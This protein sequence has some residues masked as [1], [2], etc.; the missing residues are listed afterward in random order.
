MEDLLEVL[1]GDFE[2][3]KRLCEGIESL[4]VQTNSTSTQ[5][6]GEIEE[7]GWAEDA[8]KVTEELNSQIQKLQGEIL[9]LKRVI[10]ALPETGVQ[11]QSRRQNI[12]GGEK[13]HRR[14]LVVKLPSRGFEAPF[15]RLDYEKSA[16]WI[17][18]STNVQA[19]REY[20]FDQIVSN[21]TLGHLDREVE[22][23]DRNR[24]V[25]IN[26]PKST[27]KMEIALRL[28]EV[29]ASRLVG[30]EGKRLKIMSIG[31]N[32]QQWDIDMQSKGWKEE[33]ENILVEMAENAR[34]EKITGRDE[35]GILPAK[36]LIL[37]LVMSEET[38]EGLEVVSQ[39]CKSVVTLAIMIS[40]KRYQY[41]APQ[42]RIFK[43]QGE[44]EYESIR[45]ES[46]WRQCLQDCIQSSRLT[47][48]EWVL[49]RL[50][51]RVKSMAICTVATFEPVYA[52]I[53]ATE[54]Y[55]LEFGN[56]I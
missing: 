21:Y 49:N 29:F 12:G 52:R 39:Q 54:E 34:Q 9:H 22:G 30:G 46:G 11:I 2:G 7:E 4:G 42:G 5:T 55:L 1:A 33:V 18:D 35:L 56:F 6:H 43:D 41:R 10:F 37:E 15:M 8:R 51:D 26:G 13:D 25:F 23:V 36:L 38:M 50:E 16:L 32:I 47:S 45:K 53:F 3:Y 28:G 17:R 31:I 48:T 14:V 27:N 24:L 40:K 44:S 19:F 20:R